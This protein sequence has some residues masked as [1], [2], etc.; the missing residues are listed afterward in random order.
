M[1]DY[2]HSSMYSYTNNYSYWRMNTIKIKPNQEDYSFVLL[3]LFSPETI[4]SHPHSFFRALNWGIGEIIANFIFFP[5][6]LSR[7]QLVHVH[8][9]LDQHDSARSG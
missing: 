1:N 4:L 3:L 6:S 9:C 5:Q 7:G 2:N 8:L